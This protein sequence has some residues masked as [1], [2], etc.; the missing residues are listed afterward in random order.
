MQITNVDDE[1]E[2]ENFL[3]D[4]NSCY[5]SRNPIKPPPI[6]SMRSL[7]QYV[8]EGSIPGDFVMAILQNDLYGAIGN[9]PLLEVDGII[10]LTQYLLICF[11]IQCYGNPDKVG[12][13]L[14][15]TK[16]SKMWKPTKHY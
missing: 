11:P 10:A 13:W 2:L 14:N 8:T 16:Q 9:A 15:E 7:Y 5:T 6:D 1:K 4:W 3:R 12:K